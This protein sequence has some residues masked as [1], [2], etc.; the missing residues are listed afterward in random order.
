MV[1]VRFY[2]TTL[3][4]DNGLYVQVTEVWTEL[5]HNLADSEAHSG[6]CLLPLGGRLLR[7]KIDD[8]ILEYPDAKPVSPAWKASP[9]H[10]GMTHEGSDLR[11]APLWLLRGK[12]ARKC[13]T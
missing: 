8:I 13:C 10:R 7:K 11:Q 1:G 3:V 4:L 9:F 5:G 2:V 12:G 6:S